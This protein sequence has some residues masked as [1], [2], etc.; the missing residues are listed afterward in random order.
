MKFESRPWSPLSLVLCVSSFVQW[1]CSPND[2]HEWWSNIFG[3]L[4]DQLSS[5]LP[6]HCYL[7]QKR[8][9]ASAHSLHAP[10]F[11]K[12]LIRE[13]TCKFSVHVRHFAQRSTIAIVSVCHNWILGIRTW[14]AI[15]SKQLLKVVK[16]STLL[17]LGIGM[18]PSIASRIII[19]QFWNWLAIS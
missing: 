15:D 11:K 10:L 6:D 13:K 18:G 9:T 7:S 5:S 2:S 4:L 1:P 19:M 16:S 8:L 12:N 14:S 3:L 17:A